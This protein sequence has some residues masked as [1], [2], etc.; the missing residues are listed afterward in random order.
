VVKSQRT[1]QIKVGEKVNE[2]QLVDQG[3]ITKL[4]DVKVG[5]ALKK[6]QPLITMS[7]DVF[8]ANIDLLHR[9]MYPK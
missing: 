9:V 3:V 5:D 7:D 6:G 4:E 2:P 1:Y 8:D